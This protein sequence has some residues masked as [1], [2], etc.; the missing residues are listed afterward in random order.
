MVRQRA[1]AE[2]QAEFTR[3]DDGDGGQGPDDVPILLDESRTRQAEIF[4]NFE[5]LF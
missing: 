4:L 2:H 1:A 5:Q 3:I